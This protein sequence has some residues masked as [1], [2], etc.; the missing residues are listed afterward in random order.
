MPRLS[1]TA[2]PAYRH[3]KA[4]GRAIVTLD[5]HD[6]CLGPCRSA[7]SKAEY[8][9]VIG[10]WLATGRRLPTDP[11][12]GIVAEVPAA[13]RRHAR[14]YYRDADGNVSRAVNHSTRRCG[15]C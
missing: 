3:H 12:T 9:R 13:F 1:D 15:R 4:S 7:A 8:S 5:G 2:V 14:D 10:E 6:F 11:H